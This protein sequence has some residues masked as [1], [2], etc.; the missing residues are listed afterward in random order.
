MP[1]MLLEVMFFSSWVFYNTLHDTYYII[2]KAFAYLYATFE[3]HLTTVL[4][5]YIFIW[6]T[7]IVV[8]SSS[9]KSTTEG[10]FHVWTDVDAHDNMIATQIKAL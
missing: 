3:F 4:I 10:L 9:P 5:K 1:K 7:Q 6:Y 2:V 8:A